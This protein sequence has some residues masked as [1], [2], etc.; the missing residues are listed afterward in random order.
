[1]SDKP[2]DAQP[3]EHGECVC[4]GYPRPPALLSCSPSVHLAQSFYYLLLVQRSMRS[5]RVQFVSVYIIALE[6]KEELISV[7]VPLCEFRFR[8]YKLISRRRYDTEVTRDL[9][10]FGVGSDTNFGLLS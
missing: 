6:Y 7:S 5:T 10:T 2:N 9:P 8:S 3:R 4:E 1:M